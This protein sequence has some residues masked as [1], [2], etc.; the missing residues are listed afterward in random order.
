[1]SRA[2][3]A[4][5][6]HSAAHARPGNGHEAIVH[7]MNDRGGGPR[8]GMKSAKDES[9]NRR[10]KPDERREVH[11]GLAGRLRGYFLA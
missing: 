8:Q 11:K 5:A 4:I 6:A 7:E 10:P 9:R 3:L 2:S 1:M